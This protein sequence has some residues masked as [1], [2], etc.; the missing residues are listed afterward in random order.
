MRTVIGAVLTMR[1]TGV[2]VIDVIV[3]DDRVMAAVRPMG[4]L[5]RLGGPVFEHG[6]H[7]KPSPSPCFHGPPVG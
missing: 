6:G 1:V 7:G 2:Q 4:V 5:M 3:M